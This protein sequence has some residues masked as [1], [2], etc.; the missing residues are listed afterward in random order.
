[1]RGV[2]KVAAIYDIH[3]NVRA[4]ESVLANLAAE[5]PDV[6]VVGGDVA[7]GPLPRE[8]IELLTQLEA[9]VVHFIRGNADRELLERRKRLARADALGGSEAEIWDRREDWTA[10]QLTTSHFALLESFK[11]YESIAIEGLGRTTFCHAT[12]DSD[13]TII[14]PLTP[15]S[16]LSRL[17]GGTDA[18]VIVCGHTHMQF[19]LPLAGTRLV[20][21]GSIGMPYEGTT[22]AYWALLGPDVSLR[23]TYYDT[24]AAAKEILRTDYPGAEEFVEEY[25]LS[26][27]PRDEAMRSL[28]SQAADAE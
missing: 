14:T 13:D 9:P 19:D 6:I 3:G 23:H 20:N 8:T 17:L 26:S 25:I 11:A 24:E 10:R 1:M 21:A 18:D 4:L 12:P 22:E 16:R 2:A 7:S 28:E 15:K 5:E 27:L